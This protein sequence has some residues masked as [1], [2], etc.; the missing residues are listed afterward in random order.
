MIIYYKTTI[1]QSYQTRSREPQTRTTSGKCMR[2]VVGKEV[3]K[4][5]H[6]PLSQSLVCSFIIKT[7]SWI[8]LW[9]TT[10]TSTQLIN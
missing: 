3:K 4:P 2:E 9:N 5:A 1:T 7:K 10:L 6:Y 8:V